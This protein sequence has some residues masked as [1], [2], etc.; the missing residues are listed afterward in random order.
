MELNTSHIALSTNVYVSKVLELL[1]L[2]EEILED[3][4]NKFLKC[5]WH[6]A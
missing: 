3:T 5:N 4:A 6:Y 1:H 2:K